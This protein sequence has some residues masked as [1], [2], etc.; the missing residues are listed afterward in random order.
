MPDRAACR[1]GVAREVKVGITGLRFCPLFRLGILQ[2]G[3]F[4]Q[5]HGALR[6]WNVFLIRRDRLLCGPRTLRHTVT[7]RLRC[8]ARLTPVPALFN[9]FHS[10]RT[11]VEITK[12]YGGT[13]PRE[14]PFYSVREG[15]RFLHISP[16]T[17]ADWVQN[18]WKVPGSVAKF[19][20]PLICVPNVNDGRLSFN[21][22]IEAFVL[23]SFRKNKSV[24][25]DRVKVAVYSARKN[26][27]ENRLFLKRKLAASADL[28]WDEVEVLLNLSRVNQLAFREIF[29]AHLERIDWDEETGL[30]KKLYPFIAPFRSTDS[31]VIDPRICFGQPTIKG[32]GI[33]TVA[34]MERLNAGEDQKE[35]ADDYGMEVG[36]VDDA[37]IY[38]TWKN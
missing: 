17:L 29:D 38:E 21:N 18:R 37:M 5:A 26:V 28:F 33:T 19:E 32:H 34:I 1:R 2:I 8:D 25:M 3:L 30:P 22:L 7:A 9:G 23:N 15:A 36:L 16:S 35:V 14:I 12:F 10:P 31:I 11:P 6:C 20:A 13:D 4:W 27:K 24:T